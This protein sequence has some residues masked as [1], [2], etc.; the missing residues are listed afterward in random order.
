MQAVV[1]LPR[2][3]Q[4]LYQQVKHKH[5]HRILSTIKPT[6][7]LQVSYQNN[8]NISIILKYKS[9]NLTVLSKLYPNYFIWITLLSIF[10][11]DVMPLNTLLL[12]DKSNKTQARLSATEHFNWS[13]W[14]VYYNFKMSSMTIFYSFSDIIIT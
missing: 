3:I 1:F 2:G 6:P 8:F 12:Y 5:S 10:V 7:V 14:R 13:D 11:T 4:T 9:F